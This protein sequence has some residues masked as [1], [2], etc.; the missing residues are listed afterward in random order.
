[1]DP[2][3]GFILDA[4]A[5]GYKTANV[6]Y[7]PYYALK[8]DVEVTLHFLRDGRRVMSTVEENRFQSM[9]DVKAY[10]SQVG[11]RLVRNPWGKLYTAEDF[12]ALDLGVHP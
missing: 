7:M 11:V 3:P 5:G 8:Y 6:V 2:D 9:A 4:M 1:M 10:L 12:L